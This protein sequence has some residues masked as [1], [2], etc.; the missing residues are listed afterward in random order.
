MW[1]PTKPVV[2]RI[3]T[4][5]SVGILINAESESSYLLSYKYHLLCTKEHALGRCSRVGVR[6][7]VV[8]SICIRYQNSAA[9][10]ECISHGV[11]LRS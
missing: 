6:I 3:P 9:Q 4:W 2:R 11:D 7:D 10:H 5:R 8:K 1:K